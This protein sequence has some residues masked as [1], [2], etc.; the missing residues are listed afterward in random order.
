MVSN[1]ILR[2]VEVA[3][4]FIDVRRDMARVGRNSANGVEGVKRVSGKGV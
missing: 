4:S 3:C 1:R 2:D